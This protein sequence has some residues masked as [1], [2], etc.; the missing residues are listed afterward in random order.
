MG[1][2]NFKFYIKWALHNIILTPRDKKYHIH[3][4]CLLLRGDLITLHI[5]M[6]K[7]IKSYTLLSKMELMHVNAKIIMNFDIANLNNTMNFWQDLARSPRTSIKE[8]FSMMDIR[9]II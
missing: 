5:P 4:I 2:Y 1:H 9:L 8:C 7:I 3:S 6:Q